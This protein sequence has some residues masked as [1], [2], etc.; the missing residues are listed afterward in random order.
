MFPAELKYISVFWSD[1]E[2]VVKIEPSRETIDVEVTPSGWQAETSTFPRVYHY[3]AVKLLDG[4]VHDEPYLLQT[5][6]HKQ[7]LFPIQAP[8]SKEVWWIQNSGWDNKNKRYYSELFRTA[9]RYELFVNGH[10]LVIVNDTF[11]FTVDELESY[12]SDFKNNLW[13]LILNNTSTAKASISKEIPDCFNQD[14]LDMFHSFIQSVENIVKKPNMI[15]NEVQGKMPIRSVKPV[16]RTFREYASNPN[17]KQLTSRT[18]LESYDTP[19]N[20]FIHHCINRVLYILKSLSKVANAQANI[21]KQ[22]I[23]QSKHWL[24]NNESQTIKKVDI[25]VFDNE[26]NKL[27]GDI[28]E[29]NARLKKLITKNVKSNLSEK[30]CEFGGYTIGFG[31][32]LNHSP[33]SYFVES[34]NGN[35]C[36]ETYETYVII[37][38][39][40]A[41]QVKV[42]SELPKKSEILLTGY[43]TKKP[44]V[45]GSGKK[46]Y[47][48]TYKKITDVSV[49]NSAWMNE[50][51]R[52]KFRRIELEKNNWLAPLTF[53]E[54]K[55]LAM[56]SSVANN[57]IMFFRNLEEAM[58]GFSSSLPM[59]KSR[60]AKVLAYFKE[61]KVKINANC[62]N[63]MVFI[64]NPS[65]ANTKSQFNN[66][67]TLNGLDESILNAM[68]IVDEIGLVNISNLYERWCLLQIINVLTEVYGFTVEENWQS[69]LINAVLENN[70]DVEIKLRDSARQQWMV[71]TYEKVLPSNNRPDF[72]IDLYSNVYVK[73]ENIEGNWVINGE[74]KKRL[75]IDAK[76][77][78]S[79]SEQSFHDL[80]AEM[81]TNKDYSESKMNQVFIMHPSPNVISSPTSSLG[82]G[83]Q[84]DYGQSD[85]VGH[86]YG[87]VFVSP[88]SAYSTNQDNLQRLIG[89]FIQA[90]TRV[91]FQKNSGVL[92]WHNMICIS[93]GSSEELK[94]EYKPTKSGREGW[95]ISC[96][97]CDLLTIKTVCFGCQKP[98]FK[99][100]PKWTYHRTR[101]E[102]MT[103]VV[104]PSCED[105]L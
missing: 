91:L 38:L 44:E 72:V 79:M 61:H 50:V 53:E 66:L 67:S 105:F 58:N 94:F 21:C 41:S 25:N 90:N 30:N 86:R 9:G 92:Y 74:D 87:G 64:Q 45:N 6:G 32:Q 22:K 101:A 10:K 19:E 24:E 3:I 103:N 68:M 13:M 34:L 84:C 31:N 48:L 85:K 69:N 8:G 93:C 89:M 73:D 71:L 96:A 51:S 98:L 17:A 83:R 18:Y 77:R 42:I 11:N 15:L 97:S 46:Y 88:S 47:R 36:K 37:D 76:F 59:V 40:V 2:T 54:H 75:V 49:V 70:Y 16:A 29:L 99:N 95:A 20:R 81:Y 4:K 82:W 27:E 14:V 62:P 35:N 104:C 80:V 26:I 33:Y 23:E 43:F 56:E 28:Q 57:K 1:P 60:L 39:P 65:Y 100:G 55:D 5:D 102:Q 7:V 78:G 52:L 63:S 12:L